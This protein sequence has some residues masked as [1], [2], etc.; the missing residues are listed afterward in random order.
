LV[1]SLF[2]IYADYSNHM[3]AFG[4]STK[5]LVNKDTLEALAYNAFMML[6]SLALIVKRSYVSKLLR[7]FDARQEA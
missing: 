6:L 5:G 7:N 1:G 4:E 3:K 2:G